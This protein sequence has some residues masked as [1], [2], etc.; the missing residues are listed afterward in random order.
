MSKYDRPTKG[1]TIDVY[2][3]LEA[4]DVRCPARQHAVKKLL[5]AGIRGKGNATQDL[6]EA[7]ESV[8]RAI[9][10]ET[11]REEHKIYGGL[12]ECVLCQKPIS[13]GVLMYP[14]MD[15]MACATC[16]EDAKKT[17]EE[18]VE[19]EGNYQEDPEP[20]IQAKD[21][22]YAWDVPVEPA[23]LPDLTCY[24]CGKAIDKGEDPVYQKHEGESRW[25]HREC[26]WLGI[27]TP[28]YPASSE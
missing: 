9:Q 25:M 10:M 6:T 3:V 22:D 19:R 8:Q 7:G 18:A 26:F 15:G 1:V 16:I 20:T 17:I 13:F 4:F 24:A 28:G 2:D 12:T 21:R 14:F 5:C 23:K 11:E 27:S